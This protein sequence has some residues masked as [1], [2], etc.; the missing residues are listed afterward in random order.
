MPGDLI[1]K[2]CLKFL[3]GYCQY[4]VASL[5][6][7]ACK[8]YVVQS[9]HFRIFHSHNM[10]SLHLYLSYQHTLSQLQCYWRWILSISILS[11][12]R[13]LEHGVGNKILIWS[14]QILLSKVED[15]NDVGHLLYKQGVAHSES[16]LTNK[17]W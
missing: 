3:P 16:V 13:P 12:K 11:S 15:L 6:A 1:I 17:E 7:A 4:C 14:W 5:T 10:W 9:M 2:Y 8:F